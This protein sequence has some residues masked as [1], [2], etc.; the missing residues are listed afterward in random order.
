[1]DNTPRSA[2][3]DDN[4]PTRVVTIR[5]PK[6]LHESLKAEA[7][8]HHTSINKLCIAKLLQVVDAQSHSPE[9]LTVRFHS[10]LAT[11][12]IA[13]VLSQL[14]N[15]YHHLSGDRLRIHDAEF[16]SPVTAGRAEEVR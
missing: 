16:S 5:L 12:A 7:Y 11:D 3:T 4:E 1:M 10:S 14:S 6:S 15:L 9:P 8:D 13:G 2:E